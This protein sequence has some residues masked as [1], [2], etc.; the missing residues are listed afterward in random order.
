LILNLPSLSLGFSSAPSSALTPSFWIV[1]SLPHDRS[2]PDARI[3]LFPIAAS[4]RIIR[5]SPSIASQLFIS[6][7]INGVAD[8]RKKSVALKAC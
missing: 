3:S 8:R 2:Y 7:V 6:P 5:L 1:A 4:P